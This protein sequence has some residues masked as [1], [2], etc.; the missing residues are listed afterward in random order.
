MMERLFQ[1]VFDIRSP[2]NHWGG[3][4]KRRNFMTNAGGVFGE[5]HGVLS[6]A[7]YRTG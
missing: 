3:I 4:A 2:G 1:C 5:R 6:R 7:K